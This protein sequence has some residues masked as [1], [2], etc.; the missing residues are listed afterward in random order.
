[1]LEILMVSSFVI[2]GA[3]TIWY[4]FKAKTY[5]PLGLDELALMWRMHKHKTTCKATTIETLLMKNNEVVGYQCS[6]GNRY[7]Q[8]RLIT[9]RA[10]SFTKNKL[11]PTMTTKLSGIAEL[12]T[13]MDQI[14]LNY[15]HVKQ[16]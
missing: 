16:I 10:H 15:A 6:C 9:Q 5:H 4:F 3:Y 8:K 2:L 14:G 13:S 1:M 11:V 12:K 7:Y